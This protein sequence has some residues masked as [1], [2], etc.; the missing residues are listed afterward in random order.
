M[1]NT[2]DITIA[3]N[4][5]E[6]EKALE[7]V[8]AENEKLARQLDKMREKSRRTT[9]DSSAG[10]NRTAKSIRN[11]V[12]EAVGFVSALAAVQ[13]GIQAVGEEFQKKFRNQEAA[14]VASLGPAAAIRDARYNFVADQTLSN[15]GLEPLIAQISQETRSPQ[16]VVAA[17]L[18]T[19]FSAKGSLSNQV[20][21]DAVRQALRIKP[22]DAEQAAVIAGRALD[23]AKFSGS[24]NIAANLGFL[25][26]VQSATRVTSAE[27]VGANIVPA[28]GGGTKFGDTP[29]QAAELLA[30]L[31]QLLGDEEG[32]ITST[33]FL[34]LGGQLKEF[35]PKRSTD[36]KGALA[37]KLV[38]SDARGE[39]AVP[40]EQFAEFEKAKNTRERLDVLRKSPELQRAFIGQASFEQKTRQQVLSIIRGDADALEEIK[41][42]S[43]TIRELNSKQKQLFEE[44]IRQLESGTLQQNLTLEESVD[45]AI[46]KAQ[47]G[48]TLDQRTAGARSQLE[49]ALGKVDLP[50]IDEF[51]SRVYQA[52][53]ETRL[54]SDESNPELAASETLK[55]VQQDIAQS[56][57]SIFSPKQSVKDVGTLQSV[58][59]ELEK[60]AGI[61]SQSNQSGPGFY[62]RLKERFNDSVEKTKDPQMEENNQLLREIASQGRDNGRPQQTTRPSSRLSRGSS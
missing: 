56:K 27:K 4:S 7:R 47:L 30:A 10:F 53:F 61:Q 58:R 38:G 52:Q 33:A 55:S 3:G 25:A 11:T 14:R 1:S 5:K 35:V 23:V 21:A 2:V 44:K 13:K 32:R 60:Q 29:E 26:N 16:E 22:G 24:D 9:S 39:F 28:I 45:V 37:G 62:G 43:E 12:M 59:E 17:A 19:A 34:Q 54:L 6:A 49:K 50:G 51:K 20:A 48:S 42:A 46:E 15:E 31:T 18:S 57:F 40:D 36:K 8:Q 41:K